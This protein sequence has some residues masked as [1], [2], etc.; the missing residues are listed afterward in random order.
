MSR[1]TPLNKSYEI[2]FPLITFI[3]RQEQGVNCEE[4]CKIALKQMN[5][6]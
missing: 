1:K 3:S 4:A 2:L 5:I 6:T